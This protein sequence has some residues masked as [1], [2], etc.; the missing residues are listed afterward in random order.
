MNDRQARIL[1]TG[2][3][4]QLGT[5]CRAS[6]AHHALN[7][8][9]LPEI[10][11][12]SPVSVQAAC[13]AFK[14]DCLINCAAYTA[15]DQAENDVAACSRT[16]AEGPRVLAQTCAKNNIY[17]I[18]ISTDYV[19]DGN[20]PVPQPWT[21]ADTP[22]PKTVYG[23][24]KLAGERAV[25][26]AGCHYAIL[27]TAWLYSANGKNFPKTMLRLALA[28]PD[29]TIRVVNDQHGCPT[30]AYELAQ[31]IK[32]L[33]DAPERPTGI[34]HAV[35]RNH[36]TWHGFAEAFLRLMRV[37]HSLA[38]CT[39]ADYPTPA[40]RPANS[41]LENRALDAHGLCVMNTWEEAL[42]QF[43][44]ENHDALL[45]ECRHT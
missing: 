43:V 40:K 9:D 31:Q 38:P 28:G 5:A 45:D 3:R 18:H 33:V 35:A 37:P 39:T 16:N 36:T 12:A 27:R 25:A 14:P 44:A 15:V 11:I 10:D 24:T 6:L 17:F 29:R 30:S 20:R 19:F 4:G 8:L 42:A 1:I 41:I 21:E 22:N 13:E 32:T 2:C 23:H 26:N 34:F 7:C